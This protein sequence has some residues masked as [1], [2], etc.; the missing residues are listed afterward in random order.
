VSG[1]NFHFS[2]KE[3][4]LTA[5]LFLGALGLYSLEWRH[6]LNWGWGF[7]AVGAER[8]L[9]GEIPYRDFWTMYAPGQFYLLALLFR[10]FGTHIL[11]ERVAAAVICSAAACIC[12]RLTRNFGGSG[13]SALA[14]AGIFGAAIY[15]TGYFK[16]LGTYPPTIFFILIA[17]NLITLYYKLNKL[18]YL[19]AAGLITGVVVVFKHDVG[20]YTAVAITAGLAAHHVLTA[21][22]K[23]SQVYS[24][25]LKLISYSA[26][27]TVIVLPLSIWIAMVAGSDALQDLI[28]FPLTDFPLARPEAY[29]GLLPFWVYNPSPLILLHNFFTYLIFAM[30]FGLFLLGLAATGLAIARRKPEAAALGITFSIGYLLHY[31]AAHIQINTHLITMSLYAAWL[32]I[33]FYR[34]VKPGFSTRRLSLAARWLPAVWV[35]GWFL[36]L[37]ALPVYNAWKKWPTE[38][39]ELSL[40]KLSGFRVSPERARALAELSAFVE[41]HVPPDQKLFVGLQRHDAIVIGDALP[42]FM[43]N[44]PSATRYQELHPAIADT[45]RVQREMIADLQNEHV[46]LIILK[47][48]FSDEELDGVKQDLL[49][50]LPDVGATDLDEFIHQNYMKVQ[51]FDAYE[52]WIRKGPTKAETAGV[53]DSASQDDRPTK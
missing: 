24:F 51:K 16:N 1:P 49:K 19:V 4:L 44:R 15:N 8:V 21:G 2:T 14:C 35:V 18:S 10:I 31:R 11:V 43:L 47:Y 41:T 20:A 39:A 29:P 52:V 32:G 42:Y 46:P 33:M 36:S 38:T 48:I 53:A 27:F 6:D 28:I 17:L 25:L 30:P 13:W 9:A 7:S 40:A 22:L 3:A 37:A 12:Y 34:E 5:A 26:G 50:N 45:A 23:R